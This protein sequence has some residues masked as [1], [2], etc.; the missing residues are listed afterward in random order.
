MTTSR[1]FSQRQHGGK[2]SKHT[3]RKAPDAITAEDFYLA[4]PGQVDRQDDAPGGFNKAFEGIETASSQNAPIDDL[5]ER[6]TARGLAV[7]ISFTNA[8]VKRNKDGSPSRVDYKNRMRSEGYVFTGAASDP[9]E[10]A[11]FWTEAKV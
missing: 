1:K 6:H 2:L 3:G 9:V 7:A 4:G 11:S 8:S 10:V 5:I